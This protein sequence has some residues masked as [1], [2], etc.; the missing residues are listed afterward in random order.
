MTRTRDCAR[1]SAVASPVRR[2]DG[3]W[4]EA[5]TVRASPSQ[6]A[7]MP[8]GSIGTAAHRPWV[9][10]SLKVSEAAAKT[11]STSPWV[12]ARRTSSCPAASAS[13]MHASAGCGEYTTRTRSRPSAA[14]GALSA[15]TIATACPQYCTSVPA[16]AGQ[17]VGT[18]P[19]PVNPGARGCASRSS[20]VRTAATPGSARAA[21]VSIDSTTA[22]A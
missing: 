5:H 2:I 11:A 19:W 20:A 12:P 15:I 6:S 9:N 4:L 17:A 7:I 10:V 16:S 3:V 21:A 1:P 14:S 8:R 13:S 18:N 22:E